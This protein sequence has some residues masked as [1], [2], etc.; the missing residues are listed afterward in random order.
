MM[1]PVWV[2]T[3]SDFCVEDC[4]YPAFSIES[5]ES[6][7]NLDQLMPTLSV[8]LLDLTSPIVGKEW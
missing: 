8:F 4:L 3:I 7:F 2:L 6:E 5:C 1:G